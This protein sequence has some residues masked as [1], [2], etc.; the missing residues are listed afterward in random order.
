MNRYHDD[1]PFTQLGAALLIGVVL[2]VVI[3]VC[4]WAGQ[5]KIDALIVCHVTLLIACL[6]LAAAKRRR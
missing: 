6:A 2:A 3:F 1:S 5:T 4:W